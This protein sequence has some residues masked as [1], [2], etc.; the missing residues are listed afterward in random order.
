MQFRVGVVVFATMIIGGLLAGLVVDLITTFW[1]DGIPTAS[2]WIVW[3]I[4]S[5]II[6]TVSLFAAVLR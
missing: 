4:M 1:L 2:F 6:V 3:P 5:L